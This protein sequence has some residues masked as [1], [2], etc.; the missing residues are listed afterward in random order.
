MAWL[1]PWHS[2]IKLA[3]PNANIAPSTTQFTTE[4]AATEDMALSFSISL[5][6]I[7]LG[8]IAAPGSR[9]LG[10]VVTRTPFHP[11]LLVTLHELDI[12]KI[13]AVIYLV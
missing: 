10:W 5:C 11:I 1:S 7:L 9:R 8:M 4:V 2:T 6:Q 13:L 3:K 12:G